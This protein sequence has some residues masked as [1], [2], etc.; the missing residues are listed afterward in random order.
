MAWRGAHG[1][2][3]AG[4]I[5][6]QLRARRAS[7]KPKGRRCD[8][9]PLSQTSRL[10]SM[11][12]LV[13]RSFHETCVAASVTGFAVR[14]AGGLADAGWVRGRVARTLPHVID[15][16][17]LASA[18]VLVA[19]L[20]VDPFATPWLLAKMTGLVLYIGLGVVALR[21]TVAKPVRAAAWVAALGVA[22][23]IVSVAFTKSLW[24]FLGSW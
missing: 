18:L 6:I 5:P 16:A 7:G 2:P 1:P 23:W 17:L 22:G 3:V 8:T 19:M 20:H 21:P 11:D 14:G 9:L 12:Y 13:V 10:E 4:Q 15:T 24:G